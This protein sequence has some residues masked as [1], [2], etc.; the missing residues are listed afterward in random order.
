MFYPDLFDEGLVPG[1]KKNL[2]RVVILKKNNP[3]TKDQKTWK[4]QADTSQK[5]DVRLVNK[6]MKTCSVSSVILGKMQD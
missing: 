3:L 6:C 2:C 1:Y 4:P 5:E